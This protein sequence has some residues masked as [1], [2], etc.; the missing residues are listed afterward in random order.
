VHLKIKIKTAASVQH[1]DGIFANKWAA[2]V[3]GM[4]VLGETEGN[5]VATLVAH[6]GQPWFRPRLIEC[7]AICCRTGAH[8]MRTDEH[9]ALREGFD[10]QDVQS[11]H[12]PTEIPSGGMWGM[13]WDD[14]PACGP[15]LFL[16]A[17][18]GRP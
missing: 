18:V 3:A 17:S 10:P 6:R 15:V 12:A 9:S 7:P 11:L 14:L 2:V 8:D 4:D 5:V 16:Q 13:R 1:L